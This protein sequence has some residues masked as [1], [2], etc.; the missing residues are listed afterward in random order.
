MSRWVTCFK[1]K[2]KKKRIT[3]CCELF[4]TFL[5]KSSCVRKVDHIWQQ[6]T[7]I[8]KKITQT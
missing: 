6:I 1:Q 5:I 8:I 2:S 7:D 4:A 3:Y